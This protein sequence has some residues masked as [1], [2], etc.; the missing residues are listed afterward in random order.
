MVRSR[1]I[2]WLCFNFIALVALGGS[3]AFAQIGVPN[4]PA[5]PP[6]QFINTPPF[7]T[8][9]HPLNNSHVTQ[10]WDLFHRGLVVRELHVLPRTVVIPIETAQPGSLPSTIELQQVTLPAYRVTETV[11]GFIVHDHWEVR[12]VGNAYYWTFVPTHFRRK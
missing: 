8:Q 6:N 1:R 11:G 2:R 4:P 10:P 3:P 9:P 5:V 7:G 12:P